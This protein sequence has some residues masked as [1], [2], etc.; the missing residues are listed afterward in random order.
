MSEAALLRALADSLDELEALKM[1][2]ADIVD[3]GAVTVEWTA[4][5]DHD[6]YAVTEP[7]H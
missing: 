6:G 5:N 7:G 4:G 1:F 3:P 2:P